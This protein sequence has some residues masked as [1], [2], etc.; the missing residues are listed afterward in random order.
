MDWYLAVLKKYAQFSGRARRKEYWYFTLFNVIFS[1]VLSFVDGQTGTWNQESGVGLLSGI[2]SLAV[3]IP[4]IAVGVRRL[5]DTGR[6]AWWLLI[7]LIP[8]VGV[9]IFLVFMVL[10]SQ[11]GENQY[12]PS[13][14]LAA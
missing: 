6:S 10:E 11:E 8:L 14:K 12:G 1:V 13:P 3:L 5:H 9:I 4:A 7:L 2:Y